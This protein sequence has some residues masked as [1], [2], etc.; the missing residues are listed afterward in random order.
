MRVPSV[1][2][3]PCIDVGA[4]ISHLRHPQVIHQMCCWT[5]HPQISLEGA[6]LH[7][8]HHW[9]PSDQAPSR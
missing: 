7:N 9:H 2:L 6:L 5:K 8:G 1:F 4:Q 3:A